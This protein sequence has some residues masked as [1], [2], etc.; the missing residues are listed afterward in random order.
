MLTTSKLRSSSARFSSQSSNSVC[1][2]VSNIILKPIFFLLA[3]HGHTFSFVRRELRGR[4]AAAMSKEQQQQQQQQQ[5]Q[6]TNGSSISDCLTATFKWASAASAVLVSIAV[7]YL[8][9]YQPYRNCSCDYVSV[10]WKCGCLREFVVQ[11]KLHS[12]CQPCKLTI[13]TFNLETS[14]ST[15]TTFSG[16]APMWSSRQ[17][18]G[19]RDTP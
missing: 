19:C 9:F 16:Y 13:L 1:S 3:S 6:G 2:F 7:Y 8:W 5:L 11:T 12:I 14:A 10:C 15:T 17:R 18:N 4:K